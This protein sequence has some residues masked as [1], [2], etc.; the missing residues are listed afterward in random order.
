MVAV[1]EQSRGTVSG[2]LALILE[3]VSGVAVFWVLVLR[4]EVGYVG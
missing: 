1:T 3:E 4:W 2:L